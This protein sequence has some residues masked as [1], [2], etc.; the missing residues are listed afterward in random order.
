MD[1]K[2]D[3]LHTSRHNFRRK[4][5]K[6]KSY[7]ENSTMTVCHLRESKRVSICVM[8]MEELPSAPPIPFL[9]YSCLGQEEF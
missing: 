2:K 5:E 4:K 8:E 7:D 1:L 9:E 6:T 3:E